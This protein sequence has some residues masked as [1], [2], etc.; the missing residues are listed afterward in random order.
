MGDWSPQ[1]VACWWDEGHGP[2]VGSWFTG[3]N[4][5]PQRTWETRS[6]VIDADPGRAFA[7]KVGGAWVLWAYD[8]QAL[9]TDSMRLT[10]SW[11]FLD[12]G[13]ERFVELYGEDAPRQ[14]AIRQ[15]AARS[16]IPATL[17]AIKRVLEAEPSRASD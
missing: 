11:T 14:I 10:E 1:C 2:T 8:F 6:E 4:V 5:T 12:A 13:L 7:F 15:E 9:G 16:G 17:A 3:R